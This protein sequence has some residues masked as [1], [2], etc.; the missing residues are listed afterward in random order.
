M[1]TKARSG[2][3]I[4]LTNLYQASIQVVEFF[5][6]YWVEG[7]LTVVLALWR[8][9]LFM[10]SRNLQF[11]LHTS[12]KDERVML[13]SKISDDDNMELLILN[14]GTRK[15]GAIHNLIISRFV[16]PALVLSKAIFRQFRPLRCFWV[17]KGAPVRHS[18]LPLNINEFMRNLSGT[19]TANRPPS[20]CFYERWSQGYL[21][22][23]LRHFLI[24]F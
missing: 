5:W 13:Y 12:W 10:C 19:N 18:I 15:F 9:A 6:C 1:L 4:C 16:A 2:L 23:C 24:F 8:R 20:R 3:S 14:D 17:L 22:Y 21:W 11:A 7:S